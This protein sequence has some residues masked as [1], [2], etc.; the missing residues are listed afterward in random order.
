[1]EKFSGNNPKLL[2]LGPSLEPG[3][4]LFDAKFESGNLDL[5][6]KLEDTSIYYCFMR[7]D[8]NSRGHT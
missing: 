1:M 7:V 3:E 5:V 4:L 8:T 6:F 2:K